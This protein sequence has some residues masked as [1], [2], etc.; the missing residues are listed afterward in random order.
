M[1]MSVQR[2]IKRAEKILPGVPALDEETDIRWQRIIDVSVYVATD[3][4]PI[5]SFIERWGSHQDEDLRTAIGLCLL[6][7]LLGHHFDLI[8]PRVERLAAED[9]LFAY[10]FRTCRKMGQAETS[11]NEARW[12]ELLQRI[13]GSSAA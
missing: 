5:W 10:T 8:F 3:P 4:E 7:H 2:A 11:A 1:G 12:D 9:S 6:E 13:S